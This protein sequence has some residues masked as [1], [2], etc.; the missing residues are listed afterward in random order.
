MG[1]LGSCDGVEGRL[2]RRAEAQHRARAW[3]YLRPPGIL[4]GAARDARLARS[5]SNGIH[6]LLAVELQWWWVGGAWE[7]GVGEAV[8]HQ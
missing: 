1:A 6:L 7:R 5:S 8:E 4:N 3:L 2:G